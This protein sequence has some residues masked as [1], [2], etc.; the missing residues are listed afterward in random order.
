M[1]KKRVYELA[2]ELGIDNKELISR[3]EK[4]GIAV[5][6]HS[7]TLEDNEV[8]RVT[9]EFL[10]RGSKEMVEQRIKTTVIRRRAVRVPE[11]EIVA[12]EAHVEMEEALPEKEPE[13]IVPPTEVPPA[14]IVK[15]RPIVQEKK[16]PPVVEKPLPTPV[17][18]SEPPA[19]PPIAEIPRE[20]KTKPPEK[21]KEEPVKEAIMVEPEK[22]AVAPKAVPVEVKPLPKEETIREEGKHLPGRREGRPPVPRRPVSV[23]TPAK[24]APQRETVR[25]PASRLLPA[26]VCHKKK[27]RLKSRRK[28]LRKK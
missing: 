26:A 28:S 14:E 9:K 13:K 27:G 21:I 12:E 22:A 5:K 2:R 24:P 3:L 20:E 18:P 7:G 16:V 19:A 10:D 25:K 11:E 4:L 6:S 23:G 17:I 15:P 1:S 8:D